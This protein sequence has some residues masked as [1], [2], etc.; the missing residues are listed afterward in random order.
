MNINTDLHELAACYL[1][2]ASAS[3]SLGID[4]CGGIEAC[5]VDEVYRRWAI[6]AGG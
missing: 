5:I 3:D 4:A 1:D 2:F 6:N